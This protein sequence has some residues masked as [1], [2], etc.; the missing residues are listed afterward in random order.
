MTDLASTIA[1][2]LLSC[3]STEVAKISTPP[4]HVRYAVGTEVV[5]DV[6]T[7]QDLCC[8]GLA[9]VF[10]GQ[11]YWSVDTFPEIDQIRQRSGSCPPPAWAQKFQI[12]I[13]RCA[14]T[15]DLS[16][17]ISDAQWNAAAALNME[18]A[19]ALRR[20][21]CCIREWVDA[22][23]G[24][25]LGMSLYVDQQNQV[26]PQ[27]GCLERHMEITTQFPNKDC[28]CLTGP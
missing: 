11:T 9:Y 16:A 1:A 7:T 6:S 20:I 25:L 14:P 12:G 17:I 2:A 22:Q 15:G 13:V 8:E 27:G 4:Q 24:D 3:V 10:L 28:A 26:T 19:A 21:A 23:T 18:D 5:W